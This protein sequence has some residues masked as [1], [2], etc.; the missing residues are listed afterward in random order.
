M[1]LTGHDEFHYVK[2]ALHV[3]AVGYLL[4]PLDL[5]EIESVISKVKQRCEEVAIK[6]RSTE[7]AKATIL[8]ELSYE[9]I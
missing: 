6:K 1:F 4:K 5:N 2:S 9:K 3:G 7:A 8:K